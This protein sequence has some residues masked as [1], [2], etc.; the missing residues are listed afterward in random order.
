MTPRK[1]EG[2]ARKVV[3]IRM[4]AEL[5]ERIE[6]ERLAIEKAVGF[7]PTLQ[8]MFERLLELGLGAMKEVRKQQ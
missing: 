8:D 2:D 5:L 4:R 6:R 7:R 3:S 1:P